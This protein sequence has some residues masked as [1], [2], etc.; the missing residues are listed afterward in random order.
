MEVLPPLGPDQEPLVL[1]MARFVRGITDNAD[2]G[3]DGDSGA[4]VV[5]L[6][7]TGTRSLELGAL[8]VS[9]TQIESAAVDAEPPRKLAPQV[10]V[11]AASPLG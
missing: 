4:E 5:R 7:E 10:V 11:Q 2:L 8:W 1:E 6:L 9:P 3:S